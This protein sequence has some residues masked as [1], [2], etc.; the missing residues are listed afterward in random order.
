LENIK[1]KKMLLGAFLII[2]SSVLAETVS[3]SA[4]ALEVSNVC[5]GVNY[6]QGYSYGMTN[7]VLN[8]EMQVF[9][10]HKVVLIFVGPRWDKIETSMGVYDDVYLGRVKHV[11]DVA[12]TYGVQV[13]ITIFTNTV[14][15]S[16]TIPSWV[17]PQNYQTVI[18]NATVQN[19]WVKMLGHVASLFGNTVHSYI[20]LDEPIF[21]SSHIDSSISK[22]QCIAVWQAAKNA[23]R[24]Y[25]SRPFAI[26]FDSSYFDVFKTDSNFWTVNDFACINWYQ[27]W[28][29]NHNPPSGHSESTFTAQAADVKAK[30]KLLIVGGCGYAST[31]D[32]VHVQQIG[33]ALDFF[34]QNNVDYAMAWYWS[35]TSWLDSPGWNLC[36]DSSGNPR[37]AFDT[38][39]Q[40][41]TG[42][43]PENPAVTLPT[44]GSIRYTS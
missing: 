17:S 2:V 9:K 42:V 30:G 13:S 38:L 4:G 37:P 3:P 29:D 19:A 35:S 43:P 40:Y 33:Y 34:R 7:A 28:T 39:T 8:N 11:V 12:A 16:S 1:S 27:D 14:K 18:T 31:T 15:G 6:L 44:G 25:S 10:A 26:R 24:E 23:I 20:P 36:A 22:S 5:G 41:N 21:D 32:S